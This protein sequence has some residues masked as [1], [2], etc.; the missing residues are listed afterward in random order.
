M[1][2]FQILLAS[3]WL[4]AAAGSAIAADKKIVFLA[5]PDSHGKGEHSHLAG[6]LLLQEHLKNV[7][8]VTT[9]VCTDA[10]PEKPAET[11]A[12]A[13]AVVIYADGGGGHPLLKDDRLKT[14]GDLMDKGVGLVCLH[15]AVEATPRGLPS[16]VQWLGGGYELNWSVNPMW[17]SEFKQLPEHPVT[18]G[19][20]PFTVTDE[21]YFHLRFTEGMKG[22]T[23]ILTAVAP[24]ETM[25]RPDGPYEGNPA[26]RESV[27]RGDAQTIAW[28]YERPTGGRGFG[29]TGGHY[30]NNWNDP[31]LLRLMLNAILWTAKAEV[32]AEGAR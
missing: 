30:H 9:V 10:W 24:P 5:G 19:V 12:G 17:T 2:R 14:M 7:A 29:Y 20:K 8:G 1:N 28:A 15:W 4:A 21:C 6:C 27:K 26:A 25:S 16:L 22:V 13:S 18:R 23:P 3:A 31:N 11:F 32:P